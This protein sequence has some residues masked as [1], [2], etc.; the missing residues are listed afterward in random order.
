MDEL[1]R[2]LGIGVEP[3]DLGVTH[4]CARAV[5]IFAYSIFLVRIGDKRFLS[6]KSALDAVLGFMLASVMARAINGSGNLIPTMAGGTILVLLHRIISHFAMRWHALGHIVK[7]SPDL[8]IQDGQ[9]V[10]RN[11][12]K[13]SFSEHDLQEDLRLNGVDSP[14]Q[15]KLGYIERNGSLSV[16]KR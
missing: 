3:V 12:R 1:H 15:V 16:V 14:E 4:V 13:N 2:I 10:E 6:R 9:T 5:V 8:V 7:G 11:L